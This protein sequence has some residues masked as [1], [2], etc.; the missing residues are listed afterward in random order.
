MPY[1]AMF[2]C[3]PRVELSTNPIPREVFDSVEDEQQYK[4]DLNAPTQSSKSDDDA[5]FSQRN[6][7]GSNYKNVHRAIR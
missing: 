4:K 7:F 2:H 1:E 5:I 3:A 6:I